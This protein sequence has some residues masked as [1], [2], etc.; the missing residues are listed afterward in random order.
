MELRAY[1]SGDQLSSIK[2]GMQVTVNYDTEGG[3][4]GSIR[5]TVTWISSSAE[6]TPK[7]VQ[8][9]EQRTNLVYAVKV[10]VNNKEG[11]IKIGM[12]GEVLLGKQE[13][14]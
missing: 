9:K 1:I 14:Q 8:T 4:T 12:P 13:N 10:S 3:S 11:R 2:I 6:F 5:G 7:I